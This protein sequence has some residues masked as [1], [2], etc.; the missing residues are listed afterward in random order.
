VRIEFHETELRK[1]I[2]AAGALWDQAPPLWFIPEA[3]ARR[4]GLIQRI[5]KR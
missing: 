3:E 1:Q 2:K 5:S 4:P